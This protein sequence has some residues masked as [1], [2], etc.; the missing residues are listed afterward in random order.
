MHKIGN[1]NYGCGNPKL[2]TH[3]GVTYDKSSPMEELEKAKAAVKAGADI[4]ADA[5]IGKQAYSTLKLLC[6]NLNVPVTTLPGYLICTGLG[7]HELPIEIEK[8]EILDAVES[9][10]KLGASGITVHAA[11][12]KKH[13]EI[14]DSSRC[15]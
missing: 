9:V 6:E 14:L 1:L 5:S 15:I 12:Q 8:T 11:F 10:L 3:V 4:I 7:G 2:V 13:L